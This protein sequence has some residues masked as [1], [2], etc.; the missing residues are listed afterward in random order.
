[1]IYDILIL[2][3]GWTSR[4]FIPLLEDRNYKWAATTTTGRANTI[5]FKYDPDKKTA[6]QFK[7]LPECNVILIT[8]PL[9][10][11]GQSRQVVEDYEATHNGRPHFIQLGSTGIWQISQKD[12][13]ITRHSPYDKSNPRAIAEDE[14]KSLGGVILN[15]AGLWGQDRQPRNFVQRLF[16]TK[17]SVKEK[18]S[19]HMVHGQDVA[20]AVLAVMADW[21]GPSRWMLTDMFVYDWWAL[22]AGWG[23]QNT[24]DG[25]ITAPVSSSERETTGEILSWVRDLME[26]ESVRAL[27]RSMEALQR[28]YD[29]RDFWETFKLTP[30]C[31]RI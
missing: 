27:P 20:R 12:L 21:P 22:I 7:A 23:S 31:S 14:L 3:A 30:V 2:G 19:L 8:F 13:W 11:T 17:K 16:P 25:S 1:M 6:D 26:E 10:G 18:G 5:K 4:F 15:L 28:C 24:T 9:M 29:S